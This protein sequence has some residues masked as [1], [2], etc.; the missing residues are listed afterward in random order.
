MAIKNSQK[1]KGIQLKDK[2]FRI[3]QTADDTFMLL[4]YQKRYLL[5]LGK[6]TVIKTLAIPKLI[7]ILSVLPSPGK[8]YIKN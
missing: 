4:V 3:G 7:H 5:L 8:R 6:I 1:I 2:E